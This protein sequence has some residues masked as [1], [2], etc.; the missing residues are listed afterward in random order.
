MNDDEVAIGLDVGGTK[1]A[2]ALVDR[3]GRV[4]LRQTTPTAAAQGGPAVLER[5][6]AL[7]E[8]LRIAA[9]DAGQNVIGVGV[10][11]C[12]LVDPHGNVSSGYTVRWQDTPVQAIFSARVAPA[13]VEAD[14]RAHARAEAIFGAGRGLASFVYISVGTGISSCLVLDGQPHAGVRG[15][16]LVLST[17]PIIAFDGDERK[18]EFALEAFAAGAGLVA[19]YQRQQAGVTRVEEIVA[20]A[21]HGDALA[22]TILCSGGEALGSAVAWLVNVLDPAAVIV[23]GGLG[24]AGGLYWESVVATARAH[25]FADQSRMLP[26]IHAGCGVDAG[27]IGAAARV[28]A[29]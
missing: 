22:A 7:A 3:Q 14:V 19:R 24:L 6:L 9:T 23:G 26:I 10:S 16:A 2:A 20:A 27:I 15:N 5:A 28:F 1:I 29:G 4:T 17:M 8:T 21:M 25:I 12:E 18:V 11:L 13:V